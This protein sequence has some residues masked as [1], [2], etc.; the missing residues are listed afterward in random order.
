MQQIAPIDDTLTGVTTDYHDGTTS[1]LLDRWTPMRDWLARRTER[2]LLP[3]SKAN[4]GRIGPRGLGSLSDGVPRYGVQFAVQDYLSLSSHPAV[5]EAAHV[6]IGERGVHSAGSAALMGL[7]DLVRQL[8]ARM[9]SFLGFADATVFPTGWGAGYGVIKA[10]VRPDDHVVIDVLAHACLHEGAAAGTKNVHRIRHLS[11]EAV[12]KRLQRLREAH[13]EAG[14]LVVTE[15]VFSMDSDSPDLPALQALCHRFGATLLVDVA[16]DLGALGPGGRGVPAMQ[17]MHGKHDVVMGSFS[18]S[19]AS[20]GGFVASNHPALKSALRYACGPQTFSNALSPVQAAVVMAALD[21]IDSGEGDALRAQLMQNV[22]AI[23]AGLIFAGFDVMGAPSA[24][25]PVAL[26]DTGRARLMTAAMID[27][28]VFV[29]LVEY[30]AVSR[31]SC[32]WRLQAM[33]GHGESDIETLLT[34][35][36]EVQRMFPA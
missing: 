2:G 20:N 4:H 23:R 21:I 3:Y 11:T 7:S 18:K 32:R 22:L 1:N 5:C 17:G 34:E 9:A 10:L 6:A 35:A 26:G 30:P 16:H 24:I 8:E 31:T 19:F 13:P 28:G 15:G 12:E 36:A 29:N 27:R 33:V 25:L 14:I